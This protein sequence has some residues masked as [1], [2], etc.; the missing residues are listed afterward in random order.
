MHSIIPKPIGST[1]GYNQLVIRITHKLIHKATLQAIG[2]LIAMG[3]RLHSTKICNV[4]LAGNS[5]D[6]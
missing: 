4:E 5:S 1:S 2:R 6:V 3:Q